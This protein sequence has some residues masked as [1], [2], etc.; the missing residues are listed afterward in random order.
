M[1][2]VRRVVR[3][4]SHASDLIQRRRPARKPLGRRLEIRPGEPLT[5]SANAAGPIARRP[6]P[7]TTSAEAPAARAGDVVDRRRVTGRPPGRLTHGSVTTWR[8][9]RRGWRRRRR[10]RSACWPHAWQCNDV[11]P[12]RDEVG[13]VVDGRAQRAG[14]T[15]GSA[16]TWR[17]PGRAGG[18]GDWRASRGRRPADSVRASRTAAAAP[19]RN[20][21]A[22]SAAVRASVRERGSVGVGP[23]RGSTARTARG[24]SERFPRGMSSER[25]AE[26]AATPP[27]VARSDPRRSA[28]QRGRVPACQRGRVTACQR[29]R[30]DCVTA[31]TA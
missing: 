26:F 3:G 14:L 25:S 21:R 1:L 11:A 10:A 7:A 6:A 2:V 24:R 17:R 4:D 19:P 16:T 23:T 9:P 22:G 8:R 15:R 28:C 5:T 12:V 18:G 29:D 27:Y 20:R 30:G 31:V 13:G